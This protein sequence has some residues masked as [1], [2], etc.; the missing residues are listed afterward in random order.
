M[1]RYIVARE[2]F[3]WEE[4]L[5]ANKKRDSEYARTRQIC[6]YFAYVFFKNMSYREA[7][8]IFGKDHSTAIHAVSVISEEI[9]TNVDLRKKIKDYQEKL[10]SS[11]YANWP[12]DHN[13]AD[14]LINNVQKTIKQMKIIAEAY[15]KLTGKRMIDA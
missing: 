2:G 1:C 3:V 9:K 15:C 7:G 6:F 12:S 4:F 13:K 8:A 10:T 11:F 5:L 14:Q